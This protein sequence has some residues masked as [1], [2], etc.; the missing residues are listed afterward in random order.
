MENKSAEIT[1]Y[2]CGE[3]GHKSPD[4]NKRQPNRNAQ[5]ID[6]PN[7]RGE[8]NNRSQK[9]A[10]MAQQYNDNAEKKVDNTFM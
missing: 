8:V 10:N 4:C 5:N 6:K 7:Q 1:C 9:H 2:T 3:K